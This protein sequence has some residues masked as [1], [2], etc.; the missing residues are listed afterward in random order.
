[1]TGLF[2]DPEVHLQCRERN[3]LILDFRRSFDED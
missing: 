2:S 1:V 3:V